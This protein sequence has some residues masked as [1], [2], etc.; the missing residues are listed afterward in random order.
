MLLI[1]S[2]LIVSI[3]T[4]HSASP[5]RTAEAGIPAPLSVQQTQRPIP[6]DPRSVTIQ[7]AAGGTS[8]GGPAVIVSVDKKRVRIGETVRFTLT[9]ASLVTNPQYSVT[10]DFGDGTRREIKQASIPYQYRATGHYKVFASVVAPARAYGDDDN[11]AR[12]P[13]V[14]LSAAPRSQAAGRAVTFKALITSRYPNLKY[15][16]TFADGAQTDWQDSSETAHSYKTAG[17][18]LAYVDIGGVKNGRVQRL[19]GSVRQPI[20]VLLAPFGPAELFASPAPVEVGKSVTLKARVASTDPNVRYRFAFGD[21]SRVGAWQNSSQTTHR[22]SASGTYPAAVDIGI[23]TGGTVR[24]MASARRSVEVSPVAPARIAVTLD[25]SPTSIEPGNSVTFTAK[26]DA[27]TNKLRYRFFY[28]DGSSSS[29]WQSNPQ[30]VHRYSEA[31]NYPVYVEATGTSNGRQLAVARSGT[32]QIN[33]TS[34]LA[35]TPSPSPGNPAGSLTQ[36]S[37]RGGLDQTD[38]TSPVVNPSRISSLLTSIA[39]AFR[40]NWWKL[41]L[42]LA[43]LLAAY[44]LLIPLFKPATSF[45]AVTDPGGSELEGGAQGLNIDSRVILRPN[46]AEGKYLVFTDGPH[47]V[48]N[49]RRE[50]A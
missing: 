11:N 9:P 25:A 31:G 10:I 15:R 22:Y 46:I 34:S 48:K 13:S 38:Q 24:Q 18:Y 20:Q 49:I 5:S 37:P 21:G 1:I 14:T 27:G 23:A 41:L 43:L 2:Y 3:F 45:R 30:T 26:V 7:P 8:R 33:V 42:L 6:Q 28:G 36:P 40:R 19:G 35:V 50:D 47:V 12:V 44:K 32:S 17:T 4:F 16:F 39:D 29:G